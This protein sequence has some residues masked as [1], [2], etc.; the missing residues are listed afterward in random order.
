MFTDISQYLT[1]LNLA[2]G[3]LGAA[4]LKPLYKLI[5]KIIIRMK[6]IITL[7]SRLKKLDDIHAQIMP[8]GG[9]SIKDAV[10]RIERK[11]AFNSE[12]IR[13]SDKDSGRLVLNFNQDGDLE[14]CNKATLELLDIELS[15]A[16]GQ[17]WLAFIDREYYQGVVA[18]ITN[19]IEDARDINIKLCIKG[20]S[21]TLRAS[22]LKNRDKLY[23]YL[24]ILQKNANS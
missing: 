17:G 23:G 1:L 22:V 11:L 14:W 7:S 12:W 8:N 9:S 18:E 24:G 4:A 2:L 16:M 3:I 13:I 15:D 5:K 6:D 21:Y 20:M 10:D 19:A